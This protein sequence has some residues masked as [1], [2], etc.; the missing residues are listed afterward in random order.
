MLPTHS[1]FHQ[2]QAVVGSPL[3]VPFPGT[4]QTTRTDVGGKAA[5]LICMSEAGLPVPP[6]A[7]LTSAFFA[8]WF[9]EV[10]ASATWTKLIE[11]SPDDW[12]PICSELKK[13]ALTLPLTV[14]QHDAL[15]ALL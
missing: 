5:S 13:L 15:H 7:V 8:P 10:K 9:D 14:P 11:A 12:A 4:E 3:I 1:L 2:Q 6:G